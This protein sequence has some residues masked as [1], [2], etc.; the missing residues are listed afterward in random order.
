VGALAGVGVIGMAAGALTMEGDTA[1]RSRHLALPEE[2]RNQINIDEQ[3]RHLAT[4][5]G[6]G[7]GGWAA[8]T[9]GLSEEETTKTI[10]QLE[11]S[12]RGGPAAA[13]NQADA[14][15]SAVAKHLS[16]TALKT[17]LITPPRA[18]QGAGQAL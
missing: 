17:H 11:S 6:G 7:I 4:I 10:G 18:P 14:I 2:E 3:K 12:A 8:R 9:F 16:Q 5:K 13:Q 15:G 1:G